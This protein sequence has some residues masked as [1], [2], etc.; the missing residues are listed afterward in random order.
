MAMR[1]YFDFLRGVACSIAS[2]CEPPCG[3]K[4]MLYVYARKNMLYVYARIVGYSFNSGYET[5]RDMR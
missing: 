1:R 3:L 2:G 4:N 5:G